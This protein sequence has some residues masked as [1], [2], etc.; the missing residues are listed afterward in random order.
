[1]GRKVNLTRLDKMVP[2]A[3]SWIVGWVD[4]CFQ[5]YIPFL[6]SAEHQ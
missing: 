2:S 4:E 6:G 1:V 3:G 5:R